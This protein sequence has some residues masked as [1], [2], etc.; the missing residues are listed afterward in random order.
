MTKYYL[1]RGQS[2]IRG[3][4]PALW[5]RPYTICSVTGLWC[6]RA[7]GRITPKRN[8]P[9]RDGVALHRDIIFSKNENVFSDSKVH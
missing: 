3:I 8:F 7:V 6:G 5:V 4:P 1:S 2:V 9:T